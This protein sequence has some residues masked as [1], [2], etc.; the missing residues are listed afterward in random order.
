[1]LETN[2]N[3]RTPVKPRSDVAVFASEYMDWGGHGNHILPFQ[4]HFLNDAFKRNKDGTWKY[5][6]VAMNAPRQ[7][8]KTKILTAIILYYLY[9][10][11]LNVMVT[12]H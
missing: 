10:L 7:N 8:G 11:G 3:W 2:P 1:M 4:V 5:K 6:R 12:A 9:V